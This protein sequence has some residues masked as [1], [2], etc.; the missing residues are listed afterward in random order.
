MGLEALALQVCQWGTDTKWRELASLLHEIFTP[1]GI[2]AGH[3]IAQEPA[4]YGLARFP[5][6]CPRRARNW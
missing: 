6:P 3:S 1:A 2:A 4:P 5:N